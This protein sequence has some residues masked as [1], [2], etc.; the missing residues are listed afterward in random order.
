[1]YRIN[2]MR[3][4]EDIVLIRAT[5]DIRDILES[6]NQLKNIFKDCEA[7]VVENGNKIP[8][9]EWISDLTFEYTF[10]HL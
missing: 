9:K 4:K 10:P 8:Y 2:F 6:Y 7:Y 1:M 5:D 3:G